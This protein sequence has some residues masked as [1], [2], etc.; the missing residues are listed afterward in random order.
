MLAG[1]ERLLDDLNPAQREAVTSGEG[2]LLVLAGAGSGKTRVIAHR[3]AWLTGVQGLSPRNLLAVTFTNKAAE[4]MARRVDNLLLPAGL[5][6]PL[7]ATFHSACVRVLRQHGENIGLPRTFMI[8]DEDDRQALVKECMKEGELADRQFT[9]SAAVHRISYWK[10]QMAGVP[11]ALRDARGPWEQKAALVYS[12]YEKRLQEVGVVDFDDLLLLVVRLLSELP[13]VLAWYRGLWRHMLVDEYQDTNRAQYRIIRLLTGEHRNI[14]VVGDP[15]QCVVEGTLIETPRG[16]KPVEQIREGEQIVAGT[17]WGSAGLARVEAVRRSPFDGVVVSIKTE[18]GRELRATPNHMLFARIDPDPNCHYVYLMYQERLGYRIGVTR[19]VRSGDEKALVCGFTIRTNQEIADRLWILAT[20]ESL[21]D[22]QY[23]ESYFSA[24]YGL[25]T[26]VFHVRGRRM[27]L[28]QAHI[29]RLYGD[30]DTRSRAERLMSDMLLFSDYP[31]HRAGAITRGGVSRKIV[32]FTMFGDPRPHGWH[33]HRI[34]L[35]SSDEALWEAV[36]LVA[37]PRRGKRR[38][39]RIETSRKDYDKGLEFVRGLCQ[40]ANLQLVRRARLTRNRAFQFMPASHVRPGMIVPIVEAGGVREARVAAV[41]LRGY[42]G[43]VYD[44]TV[45]NLRNYVAGGLV[46]HNSIY[47]WRGADI[48]NILDFENDYPGTKVVRLEQ[49]YRSTQRIL[50]LAAEVITNN[51]QR[52]DKTLWT[53]NPEGD[54]ARLYRAWDEHEEANFVAQSIVMLRGE[55]VPG[56]GV[57]VFYRTNAQSRVLEDALRRARISYVIVGGMRF[58]ERKEIKDTL[59]YLK[60]TINPSDDIAFRRAIQTPARG[61]GATT[62][63][64]LDEVAAHEGKPLLAVAADPPIDLRG[65]PRKTLEDFSAMIARLGA[66]RRTMAPPQF[67]DGVLNESGYREALKQERSP[68]AEARLENLEE[69]I[70]AAE[71]YTHSQPAPTLEGFLDGVALMSDIDE[72]KDEASRVTLMTLHSAKGLEFPVVFMTGMEEGIFPHARS[73]NEQEEIEEERRLCYV[74][75]TRARERL[76]LSY[77]LHR[78]VHGYGVGEPSRFLR[79]MPQD[80]ILAL[81]VRSEPPPE[82]IRDAVAHAAAAAVSQEDLPFTVGARVRH[83]RWGE[84]MVVGVEK[85][86]ADIIVTVRFASVGR[87]RLS[88]Q[89]AHLE[90]L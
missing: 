50:S 28:T 24:Q 82:M 81:N 25:P 34:Q 19:G 4:E 32:H 37:R 1:L 54:K 85:E 70:A 68:E 76:Y 65:K 41:E 64:R 21:A 15:D 16:A 43:L 39:W 7:I 38:T 26:M 45:E 66:Q 63:A 35:V 86:G 14:C 60:L 58:Y 13:E 33:E 29:D 2:P 36:S 57:A 8:Y 69:L 44:L 42:Q 17:G 75:L 84:G 10:N 56:E 77:A 12:R 48:R 59:A 67:M 27:A 79:E 23:L 6:A 3:I 22:A 55:G 40:V 74:G 62:L 53:E 11:D 20:C 72:L 61:I 5:K 88:L 46:V 49:N 52:K 9:P 71:D 78:R 47:K 80:Q 30:I 90:E 89:Y 83:A 18:D 73:M 51:V 31:H 87:K